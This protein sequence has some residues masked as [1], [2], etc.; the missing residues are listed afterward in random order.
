MTEFTD[1]NLPKLISRGVPPKL[2][3]EAITIL[4]RQNKG[5]LP[6]PLE[7]EDLNTVR[8]AWTCMTA[9]DNAMTEP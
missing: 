7:N 5:L 4:D 9:Q 8:S 1:T 2:A 6:V 3:K